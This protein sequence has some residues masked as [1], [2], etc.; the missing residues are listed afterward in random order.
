MTDPPAQ[1]QAQAVQAGTSQSFVLPSNLPLPKALSFDNNL[2]TPWKLW[3]QA[4]KRYEIT[5]GVHKQEGVVRILTL[6]SII[7]EDGTFT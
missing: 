1:A 5:T 4:W 7:D 3:K 2:A 6:L